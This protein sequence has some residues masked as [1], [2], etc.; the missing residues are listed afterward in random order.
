M[1]NKQNNRAAWPEKRLLRRV[2]LVGS[3]VLVAGCNG[4]QAEPES[5]EEAV[6]Q[7]AVYQ[8]Y[9]VHNEGTAPPCANDDC[10]YPRKE[11]EP[12]NPVY[13]EYWVSDWTMYRVFNNYIDN[14]PPYQ[15]K[16]PAALKPG[17]DYEAS[18]GTT[19]YDST[20]TGPGGEGAMM[21]HYEKRCLPIFPISNDYTCSFIS[22]GNTAFF[23]TYDDRPDWMPEVC[24]FS[25]FNHPPRRDFIKHLPY[26][27]ADSTRIG[28]GGQGYS[29]WVSHMD[30]SI[31]QA[32]VVPD[33]TS[34]GGILFGYGFQA[35]GDAVLPQSFYFSGVPVLQN[36]GEMVPFAPI[37]SQNYTGFQ[38]VQ[39]DPAKTWDKVNT[40]DPATLPQCR[41]FD[42]PE[43]IV[44]MV[45][46]AQPIPTWGTIGRGRGK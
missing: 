32:G 5:V 41:L 7:G 44:E 35:K 43:E 8:T 42:P 4:Q 11:G 23:V 36:G 31:M 30:G 25:K 29:F 13:P 12:A 40:L 2:A 1:S 18:S 28:T 39:P 45:E 20:W 38:P 34:N 22:L 9:G 6:D 33:Q 46:N 24:L 10:T 37:V 16:P 3:V 26:V 17:T 21:E 15:G 19:Y 27:A 14:P